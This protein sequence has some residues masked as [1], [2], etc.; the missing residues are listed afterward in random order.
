VIIGQFFERVGPRV[1]M[2]I[3]FTSILIDA[4][5]LLVLVVVLPR[6]KPTQAG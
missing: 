3:L 2:P 1:T 4:I 6:R 5:I